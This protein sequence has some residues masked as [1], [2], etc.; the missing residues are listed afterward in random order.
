MTDEPADDDE[1]GAELRALASPSPDLVD[2]LLRAQ[3]SRALFASD[4]TLPSV[5][6]FEIRG[7][8]GRGM[9]IV[10][11]AWDPRL[12]RRVA[13]K[14]V[15][16]IGDD[17]DRVYAEA[18]ALAKL[19]HP[20]VVTVH[21][22]ELIGDQ[23]AIALE[24]IDG[25]D[26]RN[27]Q[28]ATSPPSA[29]V[30]RI[31]IEAGRGLVA[32]HAAGLV[33][34]DVKPENIL[35]GTDG[36]ARIG[37]F[38]LARSQ[39]MYAGGTTPSGTPGYMA[40]EQREG[41]A[42]DARTDQYGFAVTVAEV[43]TATGARLPRELAAA[44]DR[45]RAEAAADRFPAMADFVGELERVA[46]APARHRRRL[47][48][49][50]LAATLAI[51]GGAIWF[52][53]PRTSSGPCLEAIGTPTWNPPREGHIRTAMAGSVLAASTM[54]RVA[55]TLARYQVA[56][57]E[58]GASA[59]TVDGPPRAARTTCLARSV[60][61][62]DA[63]LAELEHPD[64]A[65]IEHAVSA[66]LAATDLTGCSDAAPAPD[67]D[68]P[69][70]AAV[71]ALR[72][73]LDQAQTLDDAGLTKRALALASEVVAA[74]EPLGDRRLLGEAWYRLGVERASA[75]APDAEVA[76]RR[77]AS[78]AEAAGDDANAAQAW[79]RL[80]S[81]ARAAKHYDEADAAAMQAKAKL[82]RIGQPPALVGFL[83]MNLGLLAEARNDLAGARTE[84]ERCLAL[85]EPLGIDR[86]RVVGALT[87]LARILDEQG[88]P[89]QAA[90]A[91]QR[92]AE[93]A[94]KIY[95]PD[96]PNLADVLVQQAD[97]AMAGDALITAR[98]LYLRAI[99]IEEASQAP[100]LHLA[101]ALNSLA[102]AYAA[103]G[104]RA[105]TLATLRR[106]LALKEQTQGK[107]SPALVSTLVNLSQ[108]VVVADSAA[109]RAYLE[110]A[111]AIVATEPAPDRVRDHPQVELGLGAVDVEQ[112]AFDHAIAHVIAG[113]DELIAILGAS[114][115]KVASANVTLAHVYLEANRPADAVHA[116]DAVA[117]LHG[118]TPFDT[119]YAELIAAEAHFRTDDREHA[120]QLA[121]SAADRVAKVPGAAA[122]DLAKKIAA[123]RASPH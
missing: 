45:G 67:P 24:W 74:A 96:H 107:A 40:P 5:G 71:A 103:L 121:S 100:A 17:H 72:A 81:I 79:I 14:L 95:G 66:A 51:A 10:Y 68:A 82:T 16:A 31:A 106:V 55:G 114:H 123:W 44:L 92:A 115:P 112:H 83:H 60:H 23:V 101:A 12:L 7:V 48:L 97:V 2:A 80:I 65:V 8:L 29:E 122:A 63:L 53:W 19:A 35:I 102:G 21:D 89:E 13:L 52:A 6:R 85:Y 46:A 62:V 104:D 18:R 87:T 28:R 20:H 49:G 119:A 4:A 41:R 15:P 116:I 27:Y 56:L 117:E 32:A 11:D 105:A 69:N 37:D 118:R 120:L 59:C 38:G 9:T 86:P 3:V 64:P 50:G 25:S 77:A 58:A 88:Q 94:A 43:W 84:L 26:L 33:H 99:A 70:A 90:A 78:E 75:R 61:R 91:V 110:R 113:R 30:L 73:K 57:A 22:A 108:T 36:R 111:Q 42:I 76:Q 98:D 54:D 47:A 93:I 1:L 34:R 109:A 39:A